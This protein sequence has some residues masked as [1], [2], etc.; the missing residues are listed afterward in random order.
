M[1]TFFAL[2]IDGNTGPS[3]ANCSLYRNWP[4]SGKTLLLSSSGKVQKLIS[5][6]L[7]G[8]WCDVVVSSGPGKCV[9]IATSLARLR[10]KASV[11]FCHGYLPFEN[12]IN[13]LGLSDAELRAFVKWLDSCD[14]VATNSAF[15]ADFLKSRQPTLAYKVTATYLGLDYFEQSSRKASTG[16]LVVAVSGGSRPIKGNEVVAHAVSL[17]RKQGVKTEIRVFGRCYSKNESLEKLVNQCGLFR[18]QISHKEFLSELNKV[19]VFVMNSRHEPFG[20]SAIDAL[21]AGCSLLLSKHC[22]VA[23]LFELSEEDVIEDCEDANE[24]AS[25]IL[26]LANRPNSIRLYKSLDFD[27]YS[28][29]SASARLFD[30]CSRALDSA[31]SNKSRWNR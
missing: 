21:E 31:K 3:N 12:E 7:G 20:L 5:A 30:V 9:K 24:L 23:E 6:V 29:K 14:A 13:S 10:G 8:L 2:G 16:S 26:S 4:I 27:L 15:Q 25:K 18:G 1:K 17:L 11:G 22:G 28:W 19:D